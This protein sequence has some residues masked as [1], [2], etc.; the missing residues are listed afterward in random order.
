MQKAV[1]YI[2]SLAAVSYLGVQAYHLQSERV[3]ISKEYGEVETEYQELLEDNRELTAKID[4]LSEPRNL[5][6][7]LRSKFNYKSPWEKLII[8]VPEDEGE[9]RD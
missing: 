6:K 4:F 9:S 5:E 3:T 8:V 1:I 2:V 7:E